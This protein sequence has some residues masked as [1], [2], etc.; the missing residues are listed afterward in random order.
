MRPPWLFGA[1]RGSKIWQSK[2][3]EQNQE[4]GEKQNRIEGEEQS[5]TYKHTLLQCQIY[6]RP[7]SPKVFISSRLSHP[8]PYRISLHLPLGFKQNI[9]STP[10]LDLFATAAIERHAEIWH[11][12]VRLVVTRAWRLKLEKVDIE[13]LCS[14]QSRGRSPG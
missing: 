13:D 14:M 10:Q 6:S 9:L 11:K 3:E 7:T 5:S 4:R 1:L 12:K 2:A 8:H